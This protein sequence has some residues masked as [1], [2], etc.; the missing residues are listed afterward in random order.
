MT[1]LTKIIATISDMKCDPEFIRSLHE[2]GMTAVRLNTA[3]QDHEG[4]LKV[5]ESVRQI[6]ENIPIILDTKG[7]EIRTTNATEDILVK[8]GDEIKVKGD[9][10]KLST[11]DCLYVNYSGFV[12]DLSPGKLILIDDGDVELKVLKKESDTLICRVGNDGKI[13]KRKSVN[14]PDVRISLPALSEKDREYID[15]AIRH[16]I[17]F[18]A[19]SFVRTE[20]DVR[21]ILEILAAAESSCQ[22]IAKI[23]NQQGVDNIDSIISKVYG[24]MVA[25]GDLGIEIPAEEIPAIQKMII[26]KCRENCK[27]VIT[28]TQMLH[29][30]IKA[31]RPTRAEVS[32]V[33][34][35]VYDGT[36]CLMLSGETAYGSYPLKAV[37]TMVKIAHST[38]KSTKAMVNLEVNPANEIIPAFLARTAVIGTAKIPISAIV[39]DTLTGRSARYISAFR[40]DLPIYVEC[41]SPEVM[42]QLGIV[43]GVTATHMPVRHAGVEIF[44]DTSLNHLVKDGLLKRDDIILILAGHFGPSTGASFIEIATV[45]NL[46]DFEES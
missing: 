42:R 11:A 26:R 22:V 16:G 7:P 19:H 15:F 40:G 13:G 17:D 44:I 14:T 27:A 43:Y 21:E 4:S 36:D 28:A 3:H 5:I 18:I 34:N 6:S 35:A 24:V 10:D 9:P 45:R 8:A 30:M 33:A 46:L 23:E 32:D 20:D 12:Q 39:S 25:R 41:Y 38:E 29:S 1:S 37:Q 2:A 31:P